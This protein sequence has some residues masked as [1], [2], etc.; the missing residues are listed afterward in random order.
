[1]KFT[2]STQFFE[3]QFERATAAIYGRAIPISTYKHARLP[4]RPV[5]RQTRFLILSGAACAGWLLFMVNTLFLGMNW[6]V[7]RRLGHASAVWILMFAVQFG[8]LVYC[9]LIG[10]TLGFHQIAASVVNAG[11][12]HL[13]AALPGNPAAAA[14]LALLPAAMLALLPAAVLG[15]TASRLFAG[16]E[17]PTL[18]APILGSTK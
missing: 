18:P 1:L 5:T 17:T 10:P 16:I 12:L 2:N 9:D 4:D 14:M 8:F 15:W 13:S 7:Q 11:I 6:R 3:W